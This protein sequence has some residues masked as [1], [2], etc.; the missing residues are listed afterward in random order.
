MR[1]IL[2]RIGAGILALSLVFTPNISA[3]ASTTN[4][5]GSDDSSVQ[6]GGSAPHG[7][8]TSAGFCFRIMLYDVPNE[9][10]DKLWKEE[11]IKSGKYKMKSNANK[12]LDVEARNSAIYVGFEHDGNGVSK[13]VKSTY[14]V[15]D[16]QLKSGSNFNPRYIKIKSNRIISDKAFK[17]IPGMSG[18]GF[19]SGS[20][21]KEGLKWSAFFD[22][23]GD[24][25][26]G[27]NKFSGQTA[28][29]D[30]MDRLITYFEKHFGV[31]KDKYD[32]E[33][34]MIV[35][36]PMII[37]KYNGYRLL[38]SFQNAINLTGKAHKN[39]MKFYPGQDMYLRKNNNGNYTVGAQGVVKA[40]QRIAQL[41]GVKQ[42]W[43]ESKNDCKATEFYSPSSGYVCF[44]TKRIEN[45]SKVGSNVAVVCDTEPSEDAVILSKN[46]INSYQAV[47]YKEGSSRYIY[48]HA[49]DRFGKKTTKKTHRR[50][51]LGVPRDKDVDD[52][53]IVY[54]GIFTYTPHGQTKGYKRVYNVS[55][56][57]GKMLNEMDEGKVKHLELKWS[58]ESI[59]NDK[60]VADTSEYVIGT[61]YK[62]ANLRV[63]YDRDEDYDGSVVPLSKY[64][65]SHLANFYGDVTRKEI[66]LNKFYKK[67]MKST[68]YM[69]AQMDSAIESSSGEFTK[70]SGV[71]A[72]DT[73]GLGVELLV[74]NKRVTNHIVTIN[75]K[76]SESVSIK[77][78]P[79]GHGTLKT[80]D[81]KKCYT[82]TRYSKNDL[83]AVVVPNYSPKGYSESVADSIANACKADDVDTAISN[84]YYQ[85]GS[86]DKVAFRDYVSGGETISL[87]SA[88]NNKKVYGYT[89]YILQY[90][91]K[92]GKPEK[93]KGDLELKDYE[94]NYVFPSMCEEATNNGNPKVVTLRQDLCTVD[95]NE[96]Y[97][98]CSSTYWYP[99]PTDKSYQI[100][101]T[102]KG[103]KGKTIEKDDSLSGT[104][105]LLT[106]TKYISPEVPD[107][108]HLVREKALNG[109]LYDTNLGY[110]YR[111][112]Y[113][114]NLSR[115]LF[116]DRRSVSTISDQTINPNFASKV[117]DLNYGNMP[118]DVKEASSDRDSN[119]TVGDK[120]VDTFVFDAIYRATGSKTKYTK[121]S[122]TH[123]HYSYWSSWSHGCE[124]VTEHEDELLAFS[125]NGVSA[126]KVEIEID[127][128][129]HKYSTEANEVGTN[130]V[131]SAF[132]RNELRLPKT[133]GTGMT[134]TLTDDNKDVGYT[135]AYVKNSDDIVLSF[136]PEVAMQAIEYSGNK[137]ETPRD[138]ITRRVLTMGEEKRNANSSSL[139]L[140]TLRKDDDGNDLSG[141]TYSDTAVGGSKA[142]KISDMVT[143]TAGG[144]CGVAVKE[145]GFH[146]NLYG[147][148]LDVI[149][150]AN[151]ETMQIAQTGV[152]DML[153][154]VENSDDVSINYTDIIKDGSDV[155]SDWGNNHGEDAT[156]NE[157]LDWVEKITDVNNFKADI[158]MEL[159]KDGSSTPLRG[160]ANTNFNSTIGS[161]SG[162]E[163]GVDMVFPLTIR[164][165]QVAKYTVDENGYDTS[166]IDPYYE[167]FIS[168]LASDYGLIDDN[169][170]RFEQAEKLFK[171]S[172]LYTSIINAIESDKSD[173][174]NSLSQSAQSRS[175]RPS[176]IKL[177][178]ATHWYDEEVKTIV[179]RRFAYEGVH[180]QNI[181]ANDK[182]DLGDAV[183]SGSTD[184]KYTGKFGLTISITQKFKDA[185]SAQNIQFGA[186]TAKII[187]EKVLDIHI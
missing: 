17:K 4:R 141:T 159:S 47:N 11:P 29:A 149:N 57:R 71:K 181:T 173:E 179:L 185:L 12:L 165:G 155:Y 77:H 44:G 137:I 119:A 49:K 148:S 97:H 133:N 147:Y 79:E 171:S 35:V 114:F 107:K 140:F 138:G 154:G 87:G 8:G 166:T 13:S 25:E 158:D 98:A 99:F 89:L 145:T 168:Q 174:N 52:Y 96:R 88:S 18:S 100:I 40:R 45:S 1:K 103:S 7:C 33:N 6:S 113:G 56:I 111:I 124:V 184:Q 61:R 151:D 182:L 118:Q 81:D 160:S 54:S 85:F 102:E 92:G 84:F 110:N 93:V 26:G 186:S 121:H 187:R 9:G 80:V 167:K 75:V 127:S 78:T 31:K 172:G 120:I 91:N 180:F 74:K 36:E 43:V 177:G 65:N 116:G 130:S 27:L 101:V 139:Y 55:N 132:L 42:S 83:Y 66:K 28:D 105:M 156:K 162:G 108:Y 94:L 63:K 134:E 144:D 41:G 62:T 20:L 67:N 48:N 51:K 46:K 34:T 161:L 150:K 76:G 64:V 32:G 152:K 70:K 129:A 50:D 104:K 126:P 157:F 73:L 176:A 135:A 106:N 60:D 72:E 125:V 15:F 112:D 16:S 24:S 175:Q 131:A 153:S 69:L 170:T 136:Y 5:G 23:H 37:W 178:D 82:Q 183:T 90:K 2:K 22:K 68:E 58:Y 14:R 123:W 163:E 21:S 38:V 53:S 146:L 169:G 109:I 95:I 164:H 10:K 115:G 128:T 86:G 143:L 30:K 117:L 19:N 122:S 142:S 39:L 3:L 59:K